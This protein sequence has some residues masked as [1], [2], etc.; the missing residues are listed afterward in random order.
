MQGWIETAAP[1][2]A[3]AAMFVATLAVGT[4]HAADDCVA[5]PT[6][7]APQG[8]HWYYRTNHVTKTKCWYLGQSGAMRTAPAAHKAVETVGAP[9]AQA[10]AAPAPNNEAANRD[11]DIALSV[12]NYRKILATVFHTDAASTDVDA[13]TRELAAKGCRNP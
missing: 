6:G 13:Q 11:C 7:D 5:T 8:S 2:A 3:L 9:A 4:A 1:R 12:L 10:G